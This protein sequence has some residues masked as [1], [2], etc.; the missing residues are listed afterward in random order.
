[1]DLKNQS[2][3]VCIQKQ[4]KHKN[5]KMCQVVDMLKAKAEVLRVD[6]SR[7]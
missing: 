3:L 6:P 1:M 4:I 5:E 2:F 7:G